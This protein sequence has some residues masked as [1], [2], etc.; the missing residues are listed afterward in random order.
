MPER[1]IEDLLRAEYFDLLPD[2][3]K[4]AWQL[5]TEIRYHTLPILRSLN[6]YEQLIVKS[7]V[8]ECESAIRALQRRQ[9]GR[10]FNPDRP[11][12][13][14]LL[15]LPDLAGVRVLIFPR[16]RLEE[17]DRLLAKCFAGWTTD[18]VRDESGA[19]LAPKYTGYCGDV[20]E[21]VRAEFQVVPMLV[22]LFWEVEHSAM[23]KPDPSLMGIANSSQMKTLKAGVEDALARFEAGFESFVQEQSDSTSH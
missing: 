13:Y 3:R 12:D 16:G 6:Q 4:V 7:R 8:K 11:G 23:Y 2:I 17:V 19:A 5:E 9:E 1:T 10:V 14:S 18:P 21:Q 20:S 22:G 15:T